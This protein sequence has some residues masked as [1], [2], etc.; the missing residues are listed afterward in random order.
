MLVIGKAKDKIA[1]LEV[2]QG[3]GETCVRVSRIERQC[4]V[5]HCL[6]LGKPARHAMG[7]AEAE[8]GFD[9]LVVLI[10]GAAIGE[11]RLA[12]PMIGAVGV[13]EVGENA[14]P[15]RIGFGR[16]FQVGNGLAVALEAAVG[17]SQAVSDIRVS[18]RHLGGTLQRRQSVRILPGLQQGVAEAE[19]CGQVV[20]RPPSRKAAAARSN[21]RSL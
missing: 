6:G 10:E 5:Q 14:G 21:A 18:R 2:E 16:G 20:R 11:C 9:E 3:T 4:A 17:D 1:L 12:Q 19:Q 7:G 15:V 8:T 13:C